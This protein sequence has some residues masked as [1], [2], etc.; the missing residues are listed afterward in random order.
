LKGMKIYDGFERLR[1]LVEQQEKQEE[2][3]SELA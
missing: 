3:K 2:I 1:Q